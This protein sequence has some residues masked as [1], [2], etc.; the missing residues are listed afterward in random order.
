MA[1]EN[2]SHIYSHIFFCFSLCVHMPSSKSL[3]MLSIKEII[4]RKADSGGK[5]YIWA[6]HLPP[7]TLK[8]KK[9]SDLSVNST[10]FL[11]DN[12]FSLL[13]R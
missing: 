13:I 3:Q 2:I 5:I 7:R 12:Y 6:A 9:M 11:L 8:G 4:N 1:R 10:M